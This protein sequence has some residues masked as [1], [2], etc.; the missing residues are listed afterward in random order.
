[1]A[2]LYTVRSGDCAKSAADRAQRV[3]EPLSNRPVGWAC[4]L[5]STVRE[6]RAKQVSDPH[7]DASKF[8]KRS[9]DS[10]GNQ[11]SAELVDHV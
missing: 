8:G 1:M 4:V 5:Q 6:S 11:L 10:G 9:G 3:A 2:C 7:C